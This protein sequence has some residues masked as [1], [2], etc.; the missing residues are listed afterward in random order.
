[1]EEL[2]FKKEIEYLFDCDYFSDD[3]DPA[4]NEEHAKFADKLVSENMWEDVFETIKQYV[5]ENV[6]TEKQIVNFVNHYMGYGFA[7]KVIDY[8]YQ[9]IAYFYKY[10]DVDKN[11]DNGG[12]S[13][14]SFAT[15][16]LD[17]CDCIDLVEDPYYDASKDKKLLNEVE[18]VK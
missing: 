7:R 5:S 8:P 4:G 6:K 15:C 13:I 14:D 1:M 2:K 18:K 9:F 16:I 11:W 3:F 17:T 10:F 12:E